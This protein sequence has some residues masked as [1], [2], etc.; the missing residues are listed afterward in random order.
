M[1]CRFPGANDLEEFWENLRNGVESVT[2]FSDEELLETGISPEVIGN[3]NYVKA[4]PVLEEDVG[5]F[6]AAFFGYSPREAESMDPQHRLFLECAWNALETAGYEPK[7]YPGGIGVFGGA[8]LSTY[9]LNLAGNPDFISSLGEYEAG[10]QIAIGTD[11]DSL[12]TSVSYKLNLKGPSL[13]VQTFCSRPW[14]PLT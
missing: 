2:F 11:K 13:S 10:Y 14:S 3:P 5:L 6:D 8:N 4:R 9:L 12:A 7:S 1:A